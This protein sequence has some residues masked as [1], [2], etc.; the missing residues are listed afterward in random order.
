MVKVSV[1]TEGD[2]KEGVF[3]DMGD[4]RLG[5]TF[6]SKLTVEGK[7]YYSHCCKKEMKRGWEGAEYR[8]KIDKVNFA[9]QGFKAIKDIE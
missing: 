1:E 2:L 4:V 6:I 9:A 5:D 8:Y 7:S 3:E